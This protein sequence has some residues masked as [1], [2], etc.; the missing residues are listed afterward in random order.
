M[1][2]LILG[3][4][5]MLGHQL[6]RTL[7]DRIETYVTFRRINSSLPDYFDR[8]HLLEGVDAADFDSVIQAVGKVH[9]D[10]VINCIGVVKQQNTAKDPII[11][12]SINS[13]FP[14]RL[15]RLCQAAQARL[16]HVST[17]CVFSG[18]KGNYTEADYPDAEDL[19]GRSK[20][21]GEIQGTGRLTLRTSIIGRELGTRQ[22]LVEWFLSNQG[23][24]VKGY[25]KAIFSGLTTDALAELVGRVILHHPQLEGLWHVAAEPINKFAL[26][27]LV[28]EVFEADIAIE[29]EDQ[30]CCDRSLCDNRFR[31]ATG[32]APPEW[33]AM[34]RAMRYAA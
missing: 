4:S 6:Y 9:P 29:P 34:I 24:K 22:G 16:I 33:P 27:S 20:L 31:K 32:W 15:A 12:L 13:L 8:S 19:Y 14:H 17:D 10:V 5:G 2:I 23:Q 1:K 21:L 28:R 26:I 11:C 18:K 3:G 7:H 25:R 30:F